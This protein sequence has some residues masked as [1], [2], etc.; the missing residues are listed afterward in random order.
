ML[1]VIE[2]RLRSHHKKMKFFIVDFFVN[3]SKSEVYRGFF[4]IY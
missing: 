1:T 3:K 4:H 2:I